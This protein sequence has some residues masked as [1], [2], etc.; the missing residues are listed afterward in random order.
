MTAA[1]EYNAA[2][3]SG[4]SRTDQDATGRVDLGYELLSRSVGTRRWNIVGTT[5]DRQEAVDWA[6]RSGF[7][8]PRERR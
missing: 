4:Y 8:L 1:T 3:I 7:K 6:A 5:Q 2:V